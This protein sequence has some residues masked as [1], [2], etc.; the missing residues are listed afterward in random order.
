VFHGEGGWKTSGMRVVVTGAT[1]NLG[2]SVVRAL[3]ADDRIDSI[4]GIARRRPAGA[5]PK[6]EYETANVERDDL[7]PLFADADAVVHLAWRIQPSHRPRDLWQTNV[8]G[9]ARVFAAAVE[10]GVK[11]LVHG[12]SVGVYSPGPKHEAV[13]EMWPRDGVR[14]SFY[15]RHKAEAESRLDRVE[16]ENPG[17]RVVRM[18]PGL[19]FKREAASGVRRLFMGPL[20]PTPLLRRSL[21]RVV[22]DIPG[23]RVQAVHADDVARAYLEA[24][25]R[26]VVGAFNV[27]AEPVLDA[28]VLA[29]ALDARTFRLPR[30][31]A[32]AL[33]AASW[34]LHLQPT[35][36][37]WLDLGLGVPLMTCE[38]ARDE[39]GWRPRVTSVEA[40]AE[41]IAGLR[42]GA[43]GE[44]PPL[45]NDAGGPARVGELL[46]GVGARE[47]IDTTESEKGIRE[48]EK[49]A[50]G[51]SNEH[52]KQ[53]AAA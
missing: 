24:V 4:L 26:D 27:A 31:A 29:R 5:D 21:L 50:T 53:S 7:V 38:R 8:E 6:T 9:S 42:E 32:R 47:Q 30:V 49:I 10:A 45:A 51:L 48:V 44:T 13:D 39:L 2:T 18:R 22:P 28:E 33:T 20:L 1:G 12:S 3:A 35:P 43:G 23:L 15:G 16:A 11:A 17:L 46:S 14:S 34:R 19:V 25:V 36:P 37:G 41:L 52:A 40:L